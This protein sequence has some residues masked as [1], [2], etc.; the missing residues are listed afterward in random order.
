MGKKDLKD[1][2]SIQETAQ[3]DYYSIPNYKRDKPWETHEPRWNKISKASKRS[4]LYYLVAPPAPLEHIYR[5]YRNP[6]GNLFQEGTSETTTFIKIKNIGKEKP[7][8][9]QGR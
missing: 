7:K 5:P 6:I 8:P 1:K 4:M 9:S 2:H 3:T